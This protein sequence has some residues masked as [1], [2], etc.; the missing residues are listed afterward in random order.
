MRKLA[1]L[2]ALYTAHI[3]GLQLVW[4]LRLP[5]NIIAVFD[6]EAQRFS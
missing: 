6:S 2:I 3:Y 1:E 5:S 4:E